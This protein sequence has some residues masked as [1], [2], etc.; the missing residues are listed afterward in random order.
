[1]LRELPP[2]QVEEGGH[3]GNE[4]RREWDGEAGGV[5]VDAAVGGMAK[6]GEQCAGH[7]RESGGEGPEDHGGG[8]S[9]YRVWCG[10]VELATEVVGVVLDCESSAV[11]KGD[12]GC[13][14]LAD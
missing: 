7:L 5:R 12:G 11:V 10:L 14:L 1:M 6:G 13:W 2:D 9:G 8:L 4:G 3:V